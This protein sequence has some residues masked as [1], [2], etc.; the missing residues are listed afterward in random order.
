MTES[1]ESGQWQ[2]QQLCHAVQALACPAETQVT[3]YP[4]FVCKCDELALDFDASLRSAPLNTLTNEQQ[5]SLRALDHKLKAMSRGGR[6]YRDELWF[7]ESSLCS[8]PHWEDVRAL[9]LVVLDA[10]GW[11]K[12]PPPI[13]PNDRGTFYAPG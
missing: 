4:S 1:R 10:F 7:D 3:L 2:G 12:E 8:S 11:P 13:D 9:A 5:H 6:N